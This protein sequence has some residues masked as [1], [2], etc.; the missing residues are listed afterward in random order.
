MRPTDAD[1]LTAALRRARPPGAIARGLGRSYGDAARLSG[2]LVLDATGLRGWTLAADAGQVTA[3]AGETIAGLLRALAPRGWLLPVVPGTQHVTV[4]GAIASDIH[5][6]NHPSAGSFGR[7]VTALGLLRSDGEV[8]ELRPD[9]ARFHATVGGM[10]LTGAILW[11]TIALRPIDGTA[12]AVEVARAGDLDGALDALCSCEA[13]YRVA[14]LD[15]LGT[16]PGRGVVTRA[17]HVAG[18]ETR[19]PRRTRFDVPAVG[20]RGLLAP[21]V[22]RA[23]NALRFAAAPRRGRRRDFSG[24]M[25]PLDALGAWPRLYGRHGL[26][27]YQFVVP[28]GRERVLHEAIARV[29]RHR[30]PCYLAVLKRFGAGGRSPLS[31][32]LPGFSLAMDLPRAAPGL[33][34]L[35]GELDEL[36][37]AAGGRVYLT[38]DALLRPDALRAMYPRLSEWQRTRAAMDP[39]GIWRSDLALRTGLLDAA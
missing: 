8:L 26:A 22:G 7:H 4:G 23:Y 21:A 27:Q 9:D 31:F 33:A 38:K 20:G 18:D 13:E 32:P 1:Q 16:T 34:V 28:D 19:V 36:V 24:E 29:R 39:A 15:L 6:K 3:A 30:V 14:W 37:A 12:L 2:G 35:A 25:F 11:A 5:G 17:R 10:G